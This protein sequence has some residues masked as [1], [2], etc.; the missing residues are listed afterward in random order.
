M[1]T[2][3]ADSDTLEGKT[4]TWLFR[5]GSAGVKTLESSDGP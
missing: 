1:S 5:S 3:Q 4:K 2:V